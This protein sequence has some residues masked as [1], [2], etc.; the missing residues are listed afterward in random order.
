MDTCSLCLYVHTEIENL[1]NGLTYKQSGIPI[2]LDLLK[3]CCSKAFA[4]WYFDW[5]INSND[6]LFPMVSK[7]RD[8]ELPKSDTLLSHICPTRLAPLLVP[9]IR[10]VGSI[11]TWTDNFRQH[12]D[13]KRAKHQ[14][15]QKHWPYILTVT[16]K[17]TIQSVC[18]QHS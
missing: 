5:P 17:E 18:L 13:T 9:R 15:F 10:C 1:V 3:T 14:R 6:P 7:R 12:L 11:G 16:N 4:R 2:R 8:G